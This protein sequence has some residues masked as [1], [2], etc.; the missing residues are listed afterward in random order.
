MTGIIADLRGKPEMRTAAA[1]P[2]FELLRLEDEIAKPVKPALVVLSI[3]VGLVLLIACANVTNLLLARMAARQREM[4][5]RAAIGASGGRLAR[6]TLTESLVL[7]L[8]GGAAGVAL[9]FEG[10]ALFRR[11]GTTLARFDLG[12]ASASFPNVSAI[13]VDRGVLSFAVAASVG[14][15]LLLGCLPAV[16]TRLAQTEWLRQTGAAG[17]FGVRRGRRMRSALLV[18]QIG[19]AMSLFVMSTLLIRS[20]INLA[21]L[22]PGYDATHVLTFQVGAR[23]G[24]YSP[25]QVQAFAEDVTAR[26]RASPQVV[27]AGYARQLPMVQLYDT[28]SFSTRPPSSGDSAS[29]PGGDSR[30]VSA[31]YMQ[32]IGARLV[33]GRWPLHPRDV[34]VN[35]TLARREFGDA[36]PLGRDVFIGGSAV[37]DEV[38]GVVADERL[39]GLDRE[40]PAQFFADLSVWAGPNLLPLGPYYAVRTAGDPDAVLAI[41][42]DVVRQIDNEA[43]I[44]NVATLEAIV[45]NSV[46][47]PRMYAVL[48]GLFAAIAVGLAAIG[49]YGVVAYTVAERTREIGI[50]MALGAR[51]TE[52]LALVLRQCGALTAS[53]LLLGVAGAAA[54]SRYLEGLLFG[55]SAF[56]GA[57]VAAVGAAF[58]AGAIAATDQPARRALRVAPR[59]YSAKS[60]SG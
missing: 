30:Y 23:D 20:F 32:A 37:P 28:H 18:A 7:A 44:Y 50:R 5:V 16:R 35:E 6:Q 19:M 29:Q 55:I 36:S 15:G 12:T 8:M 21:T 39:S 51:R 43:P 60:S 3:A 57:T 53:G 31:G 9:A 47:V 11:L 1:P 54:G 17:G 25:S 33:A 40:P 38:V 48:L 58:A 14:T 41:V 2:R 45:A 13:A 49:I 26:L 4:A 27:A 52:V 10:V 46:T 59:Q 34:L 24:K 22:D 56:D 42:R